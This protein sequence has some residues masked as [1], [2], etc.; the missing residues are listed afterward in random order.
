MNQEDG[1][2]FLGFEEFVFASDN[3]VFVSVLFLLYFFPE[4]FEM[5]R[6]LVTE[7]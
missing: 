6:C 1:E 5:R 2:E 3:W 4:D 7:K